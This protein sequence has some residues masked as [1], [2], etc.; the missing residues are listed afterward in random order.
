MY[1]FIPGIPTPNG[2]LHLGHIA[3]PYLITDLMARALKQL[4]EQAMVILATDPYEIH[5]LYASEK[6][7]TTP[8]EI[9]TK[10]TAAIRKDFE[11]VNIDYDVFFDPF[12]LDVNQDFVDFQRNFIDECIRKDKVV[13]VNELFVAKNNEEIAEPYTISGLCPECS[14]S[15]GSFLCEIC[16]SHHK[17]EDL[18]NLEGQ[19]IEHGT[20]FLKAEKNSEGIISE[21]LLP[22]S[23]A[24]SDA[25]A[26]HIE[27]NNHL[28]RLTIPSRWGISYGNSMQFTY[29]A[30]LPFYMFCMKTLADRGLLKEDPF[31]GAS[32]CHVVSSFGT[33]NVIAGY[34]SIISMART[35]GYNPVS[36]I[37]TNYFYNL[38]SSKFSTSRKHV[39]NP[40]DLVLEC[41]VDPDILRLYLIKTRPTHKVTAFVVSE[42][43]DFYNQ[44]AVSLNKIIEV[45]NEQVADNTAR[46]IESEW[47][48]TNELINQKLYCLTPQGFNLEAY[49]TDLLQ[50]IEHFTAGPAKLLYQ[51]YVFS[52]IAYPAMPQISERISGCLG[53]S[54]VADRQVD[55]EQVRIEKQTSCWYKTINMSD[56]EMALPFAIV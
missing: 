48:A 27:K 9:I 28:I 43:I 50:L 29:S 47:N 10:Y 55:F 34:N 45:I 17:Q 36:Y 20:L 11:S 52:K 54:P 6:N 32:G 26:R 18:V 1:I 24:F 31:A 23:N 15:A 2:R 39:I 38:E 49:C 16:G 51:I 7:N 46:L 3:G 33:D 53:L 44:I 13:Q 4:G 41:H 37:L 42:F 56:I 22:K 19:R 12:E 35:L 14:H 40:T 30:Y 25:I 5:V 8:E 21:I